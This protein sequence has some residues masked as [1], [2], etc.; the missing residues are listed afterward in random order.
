MFDFELLLVED[1]DS[2]RRKPDDFDML[3]K[4]MMFERKAVP[5]ER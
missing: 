1:D 3:M 2:E 5:G 4:A